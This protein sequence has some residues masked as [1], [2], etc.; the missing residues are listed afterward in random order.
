MRLLWLFMTALLLVAGP[1]SS[2]SQRRVAL[3]I[4]MGQYVSVPNL[5]NPPKDARAMGESLARLGFEVDSHLDSDYRDFAKALREFGIKAQGADVA[6]IFYAG[7][8]M[9]VD[10]ENYLIPIDARLERERDLV[11]E[12]MPLERLL[13]EASQARVL[14]IVILDA[15]R[16]NPFAE[17]LAQKVQV[18][19]ARAVAVGPGLAR[20]DATPK[21][22]LVALATRADAL[23]E[24]G[25]G[26]HSPY[27]EALL[28][29][30]EMPGLELG[31]FFRRVRD[32]VLKATNGRQEPFTF[33]S[34]GAEPFYFDPLPPNAQPVVPVLAPLDI[35]DD[36]TPKPLNIAGLSD[37]DGDRLSVRIT[38]LPKGGNLQLG[39]RVLLMGDALTPE[40]LGKLTF[41]P[42]GSFTG[43]AGP[44]TF[45][46]EDGRGANVAGSLFLKIVAANRPPAVE[47]ERQLHTVALPLGL[48]VP[49]DPDGDPLSI[50][51]SEV[52]GRGVVRNSDGT[53]LKVGDRLPAEELAKLTYDPGL[54]DQ[55]EAG[56][57]AYV[58]DDQRGGRA[59]AR[60]RIAVGNR[61]AGGGGAPNVA[62]T[63]EPAKATKTASAVTVP[64]PDTP[65][66]SAAMPIIPAPPEDGALKDCRDCPALVVMQPGSFTMG[67]MGGDASSKPP[68]KVTIAKAFA[69]GK[70]EVT[71]AEWNACVQAGACKPAGEPG[72]GGDRLPVRNVHWQDAQDYVAWLSKQTG[73]KYRLPT[74]A[75]WEYAARGGA[76]SA[77]W[78]G[79][80]FG[81][82][83]A[84]CSDCGGAYDRKLPSP[85]DAFPA[86]GFGLFGTAGGVA[87]WVEDCWSPSHAGAP[88]DGS[89]RVEPNCRERV[90]RGGSWR[91]DH[92]YAASASRFY[93]D[94]DVRYIANGFRVVREMD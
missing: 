23:A 50:T 51:V 85:V 26:N 42:D 75:E 8:G 61:P 87:E 24:D 58:V 12:A 32:Q 56:A 38:G 76:A 2:A 28:A 63:H 66:K 55:G 68:H 65:P 64:L 62:T 6:L 29:N 14:G 19:R 13:G 73:R 82:G 52:P 88:K 47:A 9:Q 27:T 83:K 54:A 33:G 91:N 16:N 80:A 35:G 21:D 31:L 25:E 20:V 11:Y 78:W 10:R 1:S 34:L 46:V 18:A 77:Y 79:E 71:V 44:L 90:I 3:V 48:K 74:E 40:Q 84:N 4:G 92:S 53:A 94:A 37:P 45:T 30:L 81:K 5:P 57:F 43:Q 39:D 60:L 36:K 67:A 69:I 15:C 89:A 49:V 41:I 86:N 17:K 72:E 93:Y 7:H 70:Y 22:T 59:E